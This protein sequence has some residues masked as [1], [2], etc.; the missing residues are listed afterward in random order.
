MNIKK[1]HFYYLFVK[2][3]I[4]MKKNKKDSMSNLNVKEKMDPEKDEPNQ[5]FLGQKRKN[6]QDSEELEIKV[7]KQKEG[8]YCEN[9]NCLLD[10]KIK[11]NQNSDENE[12]K[13]YLTKYI[14]NEKEIMENTLND[15]IYSTFKNDEDKKKKNIFIKNIR[16]LC[17]ACSKKIFMKGGI[18]N[19]L[20]KKEEPNGNRPSI[21]YDEYLSQNKM[22][23]SKTNEI[24]NDLDNLI[25]EKNNQNENLINQI[26]N[27]LKENNDKLKENNLFLENYINKNKINKNENKL[28]KK[29]SP[30]INEDIENSSNES[31][32]E[33]NDMYKIS[34]KNRIAYVTKLR[35]SSNPLKKTYTILTKEP[36]YES[37]YE[38][39]LINKTK[40][41]QYNSLNQFKNYIHNFPILFNKNSY[42]ISIPV[43]AFKKNNL[44]NTL[45]DI[46]NLETNNNY[47]KY[48]I[49]SLLTPLKFQSLEIEK[50]ISKVK[51]KNNNNDFDISNNYNLHNN[52]LNNS[53]LNNNNLNNNN[54]YNNN[55]YNNNR[56]NNNVHNMN[57]GDNNNLENDISNKKL[58]LKYLLSSYELNQ[59][60]LNQINIG[61]N[62]FE[63]LINGLELNKN[64]LNDILNSNNQSTHSGNINSMHNQNNNQMGNNIMNNNNNDNFTLI[65]NLNQL[66]NNNNNNNNNNNRNEN[67]NFYNNMQSLYN[68]NIMN[69]N[70]LFPNN[71]YN[72][73]NNSPLDFLDNQHINSINSNKNNFRNNSLD[74][75]NM[76]NMFKLSPN[77]TMNL[78]FNKNMPDNFNSFIE[79][80]NEGIKKDIN[81][82][83][84]DNEIEPNDEDNH[85][86]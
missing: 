57:Y 76:N 71:S 48:K 31:D 4:K 16:N 56:F 32:D 86:N 63:N 78:N 33:N 41:F 25:K 70:S 67:L 54:N 2:E 81:E 73:N 52:I 50:Q 28:N 74:N 17:Q 46:K 29:K 5:S 82:D 36:I 37:K 60:L 45:S 30:K 53:I 12:I 75:L 15:I 69:N 61:V 22:I 43:E 19:L 79:N 66:L 68:P 1:K 51:E 8:I 11:I 27:K 47:K 6:L 39:T 24:I 72:N 7:D 14:F 26:T 35:P 18:D 83:N 9:C 38:K 58:L 77:N 10:Q 23:E 42:N 84:L 62:P 3:K 85:S 80:M 44:I 21:S 20:I 13:N 65:N 49:N 34:D 59:K 55:N 40:V 64:N